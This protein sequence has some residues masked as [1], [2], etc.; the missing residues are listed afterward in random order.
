MSARETQ[1]VSA[2]VWTWDTAS[3]M[4]GQKMSYQKDTEDK[5]D[6]SLRTKEHEGGEEE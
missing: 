2:C 4:M 5:Y 1:L 6:R 3:P